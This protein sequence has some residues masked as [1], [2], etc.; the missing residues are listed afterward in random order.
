M[1]PELAFPDEMDES[2]VLAELDES[3]EYLKQFV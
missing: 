1:F 3:V 2:D